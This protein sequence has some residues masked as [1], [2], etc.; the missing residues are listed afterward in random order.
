MLVLASTSAARRVMLHAAGVEHD[1]M[2]ANVDEEAAKAAF[3]SQGLKA[4]EMADALAELKA[5][6]ISQRI[7]D[8]LVLG[9]DQVLASADGAM[10]D[11]PASRDHAVMQLRQLRGNTHSLFSAAVIA[12][13][14]KPVWRA[15]DEAKLTMRPFSDAF[16]EEYL[17]REWPTISGCVGCYR[18]EAM[19]VQL[20]SRIR[21]DHFTIL[22]LPLMEVL[23]F[24]RIRGVLTS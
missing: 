13:G 7:P 17:D 19:G 12:Q 5:V 14:G 15:V 24:L 4:R 6:K 16:L 20:F 9:A 22:G 2:A 18:L 1:V 8:A 11:K 3:L 21:G 10:F 23:D